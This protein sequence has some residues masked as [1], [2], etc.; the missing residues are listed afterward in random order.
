MLLLHV[1]VCAC[2]IQLCMCIY[3]FAAFILLLCT[4]A[5]RH[6]SRCPDS[7]LVVEGRLN[8]EVLSTDPVPQSRP[9]IQVQTE[10]AWEMG[11]KALQQ[12]KLH[13]TPVKVQVS[14]YMYMYT[15]MFFCSAT[16]IVHEKAQLK[17]TKCSCDVTIT[18]MYMYK[19]T[20]HVCMCHDIT[21]MCTYACIH[22]NFVVY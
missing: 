1:H 22:I 15:V 11:P 5:A 14:E 20:V 16:S 13:R 2:I 9:V 21:C 12:H 8:G 4:P 6:F 10:L 18:C 17:E 3:D 7:S 19:K